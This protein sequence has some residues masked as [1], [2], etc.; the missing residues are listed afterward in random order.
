MATGHNCLQLPAPS[1]FY[2]SI[3][4]C[5]L[6]AGAKPRPF[7]PAKFTTYNLNTLSP[8]YIASP[9]VWRS[10]HGSIVKALSMG[11]VIGS[12]P[13]DPKIFLKLKPIRQIL[14]CHVAAADWAM[15][16]PIIRPHNCHVSTDDSSMPTNHKPTRVASVVT[17]RHLS[18]QPATSLVVCPVIRHPLT[19]SVPCVTLPVV[20][21]VTL[22]LVQPYAK[23][24]KSA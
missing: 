17:P 22:G 3:I 7:P 8:G 2:G 15:W 21:R 9:M 1:R 5:M 4:W 6:R 20:T 10:G 24:A 13:V 18:S 11:E 14:G 19:S 23:N 16:H 12:N